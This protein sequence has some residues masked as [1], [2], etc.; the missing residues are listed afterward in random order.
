MADI[1]VYG[2]SKTEHDKAEDRKRLG[3]DYS[4]RCSG[5]KMGKTFCSGKNWPTWI[6][7]KSMLKYAAI[8]GIA[9]PE[10]GINVGILFYPK[11]VLQ[12]WVLFFSKMPKTALNLPRLK[13]LPLMWCGSLE[14]VGS[15]SGILIVT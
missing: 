10:Y 8:Y 3:Y 15:S 12:I 13:V 7:M 4:D 1:Y 6:K 11:K 5:E 9:S 14:R 2:P